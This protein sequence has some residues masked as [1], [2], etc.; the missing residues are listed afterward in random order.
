MTTFNFGIVSNSRVATDDDPL[1]D[2]NQLGSIFNLVRLFPRSTRLYQPSS[3]NDVDGVNDDG[4]VNDD[5]D[6]D[7]FLRAT[8]CTI[9]VAT[10]VKPVLTSNQRH[11]HTANLLLKSCL[12][13]LLPLLMILMLLNVGCLTNCIISKWTIKPPPGQ[14]QGVVRLQNQ[15]WWLFPLRLVLGESQGSTVNLF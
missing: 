2:K 11:S 15:F 3:N 10:P 4:D 9:I 1:G 13:L 7:V 14:H 8:R 5:D 6:D 12:F